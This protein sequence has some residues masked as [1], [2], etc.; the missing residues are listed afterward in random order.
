MVYWKMINTEFFYVIALLIL[1]IVYTI[2]F[3][4]D[5]FMRVMLGVCAV[6]FSLATLTFVEISTSFCRGSWF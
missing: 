6:V 4:S 5:T 3:G 2:V 1:V